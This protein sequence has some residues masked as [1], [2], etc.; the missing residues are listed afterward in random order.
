MNGQNHSASDPYHSIKNPPGKFS[1]TPYFLMHLENPDHLPLTS[2]S[3]MLNVAFIFEKGLNGQNHSAAYPHHP[4]KYPS[5]SFPFPL[6]NII[7]KTLVITAHQEFGNA[8]F[9]F[10]KILP[11]IYQSFANNLLISFLVLFHF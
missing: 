7:R 11:I 4:L 9:L 2:N 10:V 3:A 8:K 1:I 5:A 6:L